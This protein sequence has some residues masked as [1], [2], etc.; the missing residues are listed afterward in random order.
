ML[1]ERRHLVIDLDPASA[2]RLEV[3]AVAWVVLEAMAGLAPAGSDV[4][5]VA[6]SARSLGELLGTSKDTVARALRSLLELG[7]VERI[8]HRHELSG[9][10]SGS[11]YQV[12]LARVG[13]SVTVSTPDA[14]GAPG[15]TVRTSARTSSDQLNLLD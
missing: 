5:E 3:G 15:S 7:V 12:A 1:P 10:F 8:D 2:M 14:R 9:Q 4:V 13:L 11:T 6:C